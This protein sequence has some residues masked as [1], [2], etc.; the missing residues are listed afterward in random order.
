VIRIASPA[1]PTGSG[2]SG[3]PSQLRFNSSLVVQLVNYLNTLATRANGSLPTDGSEAMAADMNMGGFSI[4]NVNLVDGVDIS[5]AL[6]AGTA[7]QT[8]TAN[9]TYTPNAKMLFCDVEAWGGGG[10][11]GGA[12]GTAA[13]QSSCTTGGNGGAYA[14]VRLTAAQVGASQAVTIGAGG[15][16]G[17]AGANGSPG[18][19]TTLG[20][21]LSARG[22]EGGVTTAAAANTFT[23]ANSTNISATGDIKGYTQMAASSMWQVGV[24]FILGASGASGALGGQVAGVSNTAGANANANTGAGGGGANNGASQAAHAGGVGGSGFMII[25]EYLHA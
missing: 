23:T 14:R 18:N 24:A 22:G 11:G 8:F 7:V 5:A 1:L 12:A 13:G 9:G 16:G 25:T 15:A 17:G 2:V 6:V 19:N 21:L 20:S 4:T 3:D 10:G